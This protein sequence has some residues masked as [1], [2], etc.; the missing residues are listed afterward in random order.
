M[1]VS[2]LGSIEQSP[3]QQKRINTSK[4]RQQ[5]EVD[6]CFVYSTQSFDRLKFFYMSI[7]K[8]FEK[9]KKFMKKNYFFCKF[10]Y[11]GP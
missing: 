2:Q 11:R 6:G 5:T 4:R 9:K 7:E 8:I 1:P 3:P 10:L